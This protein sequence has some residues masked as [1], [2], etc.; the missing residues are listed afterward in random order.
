MNDS[1][2][3]E[4]Q[5]RSW[6]LRRP[7]ERL[8]ESV[9]GEESAATETVPL[10]RFGEVIRWLV[11]VMGCFLLVIGGLSPRPN[12]G[13]HNSHALLQLQDSIQTPASLNDSNTEQNAV[14][15]TTLEWTFG[16]RSPSSM[17]SFINFKTNTLRH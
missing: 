1:R 9:F 3:I 16:A 4:D 13:L 2:L 12:P 7:S 8:R 17:A 11:P 6:K 10:L 14:P 15:H 5:L